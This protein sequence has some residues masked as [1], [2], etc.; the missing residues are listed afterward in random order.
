MDKYAIMDQINLHANF[1]QYFDFLRNHLTTNAHTV[2]QNL[3][4]S[5]SILRQAE[6]APLKAVF[7]TII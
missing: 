4:R 5:S 7:L 6:Y 3:D 1:D 2:S